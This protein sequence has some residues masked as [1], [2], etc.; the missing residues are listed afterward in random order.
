M[1]YMLHLTDRYEGA[2]LDGHGWVATDVAGAACRLHFDVGL[3]KTVAEDMAC[4][5]ADGTTKAEVLSLTG[6]E[7]IS[8]FDGMV[9]CV[10]S[11]EAILQA[12]GRLP[13]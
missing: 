12:G 9:R 13:I 10:Q 2:G 5:F 7:D 3:S 8:L 6:V 4:W 1:T 11:R